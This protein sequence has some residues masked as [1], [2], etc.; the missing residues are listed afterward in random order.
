MGERQEEEEKNIF[1]YK[2]NIPPKNTEQ[3][4]LSLTREVNSLRSKD[5]K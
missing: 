3:T 2:P 1:N 5:R 4:L